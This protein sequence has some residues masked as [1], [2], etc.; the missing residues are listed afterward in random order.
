MLSFSLSE[1]RENSQF[2]DAPD[3]ILRLGDIIVSYPQAVVEAMDEEKLVDV[4]IGE[5]VEHGLLH[6]LGEHHE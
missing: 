2:V 1:S 4:K 5:L 6:L 3:N